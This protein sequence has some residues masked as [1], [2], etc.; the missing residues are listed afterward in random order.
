MYLGMF[1]VTEDGQSC[2]TSYIGPRP[3]E[4]STRATSVV[5]L[6]IEGLHGDLWP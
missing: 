4:Q 3:N 1:H 2:A 5:L 6:G